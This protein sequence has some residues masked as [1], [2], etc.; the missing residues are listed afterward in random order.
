MRKKFKGIQDQ[1]KIS[2][3]KIL[4]MKIKNILET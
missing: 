1:Q 4:R 2:K 3:P